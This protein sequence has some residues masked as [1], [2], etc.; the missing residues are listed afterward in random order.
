MAD[1]RPPV[2]AVHGFKIA[3]LITLV[4][5]N[6]LITALVVFVLWQA[7]ALCSWGCLLNG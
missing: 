7:G 4:K 5:D 1:I 3:Q 6:Q 2:P